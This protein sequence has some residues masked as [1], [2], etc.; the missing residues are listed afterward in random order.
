M[1]VTEGRFH[2]GKKEDLEIVDLELGD[3]GSQNG[4]EDAKEKE[5]YWEEQSAEEAAPGSVRRTGREAVH[6][7]NEGTGNRKKPYSIVGIVLVS[8]G[9][10]CLL[11]GGGLL[12]R[13]RIDAGQNQEQMETLRNQAQDNGIPE[14]SQ[15][16][17]TDGEQTFGSREA[18][19][20]DNA[21][22]GT[23]ADS[24]STPLQTSQMPS[25]EAGGNEPVRVPN[26]YAEAYLQNEDM[27]A[28][29][30]IEDTKIDYPVM[31]T[32]EDENYYLK[33]GFDKKSNQN[34]CLILDTDSVL[35]QTPGTNLIIHG[36][37][38]K[39]GEMFGG[40][41]KYEDQS[42]CEAHKYI[43]LYTKEC[44]RN[45]EVI[46]VFRSQVF[47]KTDEVFKF[48]KF[49]QADTQEEFDNW[50]ENIMALSEYDTGVTAEF[51]DRFITLSTCVYHVENGRLVVVAKEIEPGD[52]YEPVE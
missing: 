15:Q 46:A 22:T 25:T 43:Q 4:E 51:G 37:N 36:H 10:V 39:S 23:D 16:P 48:Y 27:A 42:Y 28:W 41:T 7:K 18:Q 6:G 9:V 34:G 20:G 17:Q 8:A 21:E 11:A 33:R 14:G 49:F 40:L 52:Y 13:N 32:M 12:V 2:M 50:Y 29:L 47:K 3:L 30:K 31:Q 26:P 44:L 24:G 1:S 5:T 35:S 19:T 45:Y 38:M